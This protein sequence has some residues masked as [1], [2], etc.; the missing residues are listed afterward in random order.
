[1]WLYVSRHGKTDEN[2]KRIL[3]GQSDVARLVEEGEAHA[4]RLAEILASEGI[5]TI[6]SSPLTRAVK[7]AEPLAKR[8]GL[9]ICIE[10]RLIEMHFGEMDEKLIIEAMEHIR[11]REEDLSYK[12]PSGESYLDV[13]ARVQPVL[14]EIENLG[15]SRVLCVTH[16]GT[17]RALLALAT[18]QDLSN[19]K[20][21]TRIIHP[22]DIIYRVDPRSKICF[23]Q[24][25]NTSEKGTGLKYGNY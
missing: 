6:F 16:Q 13:I 23:W 15:A 8:L 18:G 11:R 5:N 1:M 22:N 4:N 3:S 19:P 20:N 17:S 7:T 2:V 12:F 14:Q 10:P 25:T 21:L 9:P 24:N